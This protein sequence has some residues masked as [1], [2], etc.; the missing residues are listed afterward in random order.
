MKLKIFLHK[1]T[2]LNVLFQE[3]QM[4][5]YVKKIKSDFLLSKLPQKAKMVSSETG[6]EFCVDDVVGGS[7]ELFIFHLS[8][9]SV[10]SASSVEILLRL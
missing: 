5:F 9:D 7:E 10:S 1:L 8:C 4:K 6:D 2:G 3:W